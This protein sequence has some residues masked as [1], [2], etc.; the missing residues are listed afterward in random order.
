MRMGD[1]LAWCGLSFQR[2]EV[3]GGS[4]PRASWNEADLD[5]SWEES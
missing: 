1:L 3:K 5:G 2:K 4:E